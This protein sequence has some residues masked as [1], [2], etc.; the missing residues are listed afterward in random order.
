MQ[1]TTLSG[2]TPTAADMGEAQTII[3]S[4]VERHR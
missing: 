1:A 3:L 2:G 4:R